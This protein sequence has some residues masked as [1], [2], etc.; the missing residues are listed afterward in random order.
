MENKKSKFLFYM[1]CLLL[2]SAIGIFFGLRFQTQPVYAVTNETIISEA[3]ETNSGPLTIDNLFED[4]TQ[5]SVKQ[6]YN[7][8]EK[9]EAYE[10]SVKNLDSYNK[11][12]FERAKKVVKGEVRF[13]S[14]R[15]FST[16][17]D[18]LNKLT[19]YGTIRNY[20][21]YD[22][23]MKR[24]GSDRQ[25]TG[26]YAY[27]NDKITIYMECESDNYRPYVVFTQF[28]GSSNSFKF[29]KPILNGKN[30][31]EVPDLVTEK[32]GYSKSVV[33]GGAIH[34]SNPRTHDMQGD[35][36]VYIEGGDFYPVY[37]KGEDEALFLQNLTEYYKNYQSNKSRMFDMTELVADH[38]Y[39]TIAASACYK[40][41]VT[42]GHSVNDNLISWDNY[43]RMLL[44]YSGVTFN[45]DDPDY[46]EINE[47]LNIN[48]R[49]TQ[50]LEGAG[51]YAGNDHV[52]IYKGSLWEDIAVY[53]ADGTEAMSRDWGFA[54]E[55]GHMLD[56][57]ELEITETTN[58]MY[59]KYAEMN[60]FKGAV[61][62][63]APTHDHT[64]ETFNHLVNDDT[65][66]TPFFH[67]DDQRKNYFLW[68]YLE[69][70]FP[71]FWPR[72]Q[73][74][75]RNRSVNNMMSS[76]EKM[77]FLS[78]IAAGIDLSYYF[79]RWGYKAYI[80]N[81]AFKEES[82]SQY[83]LQAMQQA[84]LD[85][86]IQR[87]FMP[88]LWYQNAQTYENLARKGLSLTD[89]IDTLFDGTQ[90][91]EILSV[92]KDGNQYTIKLK[93]FDDSR[94]L[95]YEILDT[96]TN[97]VVGF[98]YS[99]CIVLDMVGSPKFKAIAYDI[100]FRTSKPSEEKS[101]TTS[102]NKICSLNGRTY[103]SLSQA[104]NDA[105]S[106]DVIKLL[107]DVRE[108][109]IHIYNKNITITVDDSVNHNI[110]M[111]AKTKEIIYAN[112]DNTATL[113]ILGKPNAKIIFEGNNLSRQMAFIRTS[114]NGDLFI[115]N[116]YFRNSNTHNTSGLYAMNRGDITFKNCEFE[117]LR[118]ANGGAIYIN[119]TVNVSFDDCVFAN[120]FS[121]N[122]GGAIMASCENLNI[123]N[124]VFDGNRAKSGTAVCHNSGQHL[125]IKNTTLNT[126][127]TDAIAVKESA[128]D[129]KIYADCHLEG[130]LYSSKTITLCNGMFSVVGNK[131]VTFDFS[132]LEK[133]IPAFESENFEIS[134]E[135]LAKLNNMDDNTFRLENGKVYI[136]NDKCTLKFYCNGQEIDKEVER[137]DMLTLDGSLFILD[138]KYPETFTEHGGKSYSYGEKFEVKG[139]MI[140][141]VTLADLLKIKWIYL[142][143][144]KEEEISPRKVYL[145]Q[146][147]GV[148]NVLGWLIDEKIYN[149]GTFVEITENK[150][151]LAI[152]E[153]YLYVVF[154][155]NGE[156]IAQQNCKYNAS[157]SAPMLNNGYLWFANNVTYSPNSNI[158]VKSDTVFNSISAD[159]PIPKNLEDLSIT[160][161]KN[162]FVY[163]GF[164][165]TPE[166]TIMDS[167][168]ELMKNGDYKVD[169]FNNKN[170]GKA[171]LV[172]TSLSENYYGTVTIYFDILKAEGSGMV[173][174]AS[175]EYGQNPTEILINSNTNPK[176]GA[177]VY[178]K[179]KTSNSYSEIRPTNAGEYDVKVVLLSSKNY[180]ELTLFTTLTILKADHPKEM[181]Q[182]EMTVGRKVAVLSMIKLPQG[183]SW[184]NQNRKIDSEIIIEGAEY[185]DKINY[186]TYQVEITI[187]KE[188][189]KEI[190]TITLKLERNVF[191]Y[192]GTEKEPKIIAIDGDYTLLLDTDFE[193]QYQNNK[194]A[195]DGQVIVTGINDYKGTK[196]LEFTIS[197]AE[198]PSVNNATIRLDH[199]VTKLSEIQLPDGFVW[200]NGDLEITADR[201]RAKAIYIDK[202]AENYKT[203]EIYFEIISPVPQN[204]PET[205]NL[206][207]LAI[208][209]PVAALLVGWAVYAII[210]RRKN[211]WWKGL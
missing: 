193:L 133:D 203:K 38:V 59:A 12:D 3:S 181:P 130:I 76:T 106:N 170:A 139:D 77:V 47:H 42:N 86:E 137:G 207:W 6:K 72:L 111:F 68:W 150:S 156:I 45:A 97:K 78:S 93:D 98:T 173:S 171:Y 67:T 188:E 4:Y 95:G 41:Y 8:I 142:K 51:A 11:E 54:H 58:N 87:D 165:F 89:E 44:E 115:E 70:A 157:V 196:E 123:T 28:E 27:A 61:P 104:I 155:N 100:Y 138:D 24:F 119:N 90:S 113:K 183:W 79:E 201:M 5:T 105:A 17:D 63:D 33:H 195:G 60:L 174:V 21:Q 83:F 151:I 53:V 48:I 128:G 26:I 127:Q 103:T 62:S 182:E 107:D 82:A 140:F 189:P 29:E 46:R 199:Q 10:E 206:I 205:N 109:G 65:A 9:I 122:S 35:V 132:E 175:Y 50:N 117:N 178:Y 211:K 164:E 31:F 208:V 99:N 92:F 20:C 146:K 187:K 200:E 73:N 75:Y 55:I 120:N 15:E 143:S 2:L 153:G 71:G 160:L 66:K 94:L 37:K 25:P 159:A 129:I 198:K 116:A 176:E 30:V 169:Y 43:M 110:I 190:S 209:V 101:A 14:H 121:S 197:K 56:T 40:E 162:R 145:P 191:V 152:Y 167:E 80:S 184:N 13:D 126:L 179:L 131:K 39:F 204:E 136:G 163:S 7:S 135:V 52:G 194:L 36:K 57:S 84:E 49:D 149:T 158:I 161:T 125:I 124:C 18:A 114:G 172:I 177:K 19:Q 23:H 166:V 74:L 134:D 210:R 141:D 22:M 64:Q 91:C 69:A 154:K 112:G 202:D 34:L 96:T 102:E 186:N 32:P 144:E 168:H 16:L 108:E 1:S 147:E 185:F 81:N 118:G 85:N 88:K 180:N 192:D 148:N